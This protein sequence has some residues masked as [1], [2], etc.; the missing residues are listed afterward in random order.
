MLG[1]GTHSLRYGD[2]SPRSSAP[3]APRDFVHSCEPPSSPGAVPS[4]PL[5]FIGLIPS[6]RGVLVLH[7][8]RARTAGTSGWQPGGAGCGQAAGPPLPGRSHSRPW[9]CVSPR[10]VSPNYVSPRCVSPPCVAK[11]QIGSGSGSPAGTDA[12]LFAGGL[13]GGKPRLDTGR[14]PGGGRPEGRAAGWGGVGGMLPRGEARADQSRA[15]GLAPGLCSTGDFAAVPASGGAA[16]R[17]GGV[18]GRRGV[19]GQS[20]SSV[21]RSA[22]VRLWGQDE[23]PPRQTQ[24][25]WGGRIPAREETSRGPG[26]SGRKTKPGRESR[27]GPRR[28]VVPAAGGPAAPGLPSPGRP[29]SARP[30]GGGAALTPALQQRRAAERSR[31][32]GLGSLRSAAL[33]HCRSP[34]LPRALLL[35]PPPF[36]SGSAAR[37]AGRPRRALLLLARVTGPGNDRAVP[38]TLPWGGGHAATVLCPLPTGDVSV[39]GYR[40]PQREWRERPVPSGQPPSRPPVPEPPGAAPAPRPDTRNL[41]RPRGAGGAVRPDGPPVS[42]GPGTARSRPPGLPGTTSG[43][44]SGPAETR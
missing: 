7:G 24:G 26:R 27:G 18:G 6:L 34:L 39:T 33:Q 17:G 13:R 38:G 21:A 31:A 15:R 29:G 30:A 16:M 5:A 20:G 43:A 35:P 2:G 12:A 22:C 4:P 8:R 11:G 41:P 44:W 9:R 1:M 3:P 25:D 28:G 32:A 36:G 14:H 19:S 42:R 37:G 40:W 23:A 10:C